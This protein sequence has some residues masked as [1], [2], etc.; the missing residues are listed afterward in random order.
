MSF[1]RYFK[2]MLL[3]SLGIPI[4][5]V[6]LD[7]H[8]ANS[9]GFINNIS[10][11]GNAFAAGAA[12]TDD[13]SV[14]YYNPAG[15]TYITHQQLV[16]GIAIGTAIKTFKGTTLLKPIHFTQTGTA[17]A[18]VLGVIPFAYYALPLSKRFVMG[19]GMSAVGGTGQVYPDNSILR[20]TSTKS[21][22]GIIDLS[23]S[24]GIKITN[25]LSAGLGFDVNYIFGNLN[26][27]APS[28]PP[29]SPDSKILTAASVVGY[30]YHLGLLYEV[31]P[32]TKIGAAYRSR[33][34][35]AMKGSSDYIVNPGSRLI[36]DFTTNNFKFHTAFAPSTNVSVYHKITPRWAVMGG[37][38]YTEWS[39]LKTATLNNVASPRGP[40]SG[41]SILNYS[42]T[43]RF[44]A[45]VNYKATDKWLLRMGAFYDQDP[46]DHKLIS[47][48]GVTNS[49]VILTAI[50]ARYQVTKDTSM[51][52]AYGYYFYRK[53]N[54]GHYTPISQEVGI[55][56]TKNSHLF[57]VQL[58]V[59]I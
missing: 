2:K 11:A 45:A 43:W 55:Q 26:T 30:G 13:A 27:M 46:S 56:E 8:A 50:G 52:M 9:Q 23:P 21:F 29:G 4:F 40:I 5:S 59:N 20:Y 15:L 41:T 38:D 17:T 44:S 57:G 34:N 16:N 7:L 39:I 3:I 49:N 19:F 36:T 12:V 32:C 1:F 37:V 14:Q 22:V 24:L 33:V 28:G 42:D 25:T 10:G 54:I 53:V 51:D 47:A 31:T 18:Y 35:F 58:N 6:S 48:E